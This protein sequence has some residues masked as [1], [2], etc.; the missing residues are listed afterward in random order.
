MSQLTKNFKERFLLTALIFNNVYIFIITNLFYTSTFGADYERYVNYLEYFIT[1]RESTD[2]DQGSLYFYL[3]S[4]GIKLNSK[5]I[6]P[7]NLDATISYSIQLVNF[8]LVLITLF[9]F[10][11][12]LRL[13]SFDKIPILAVLNIIVFSPQ[14]LALRLTMKPEIIILSLLPYLLIGV[15]MYMRNKKSRYLVFSSICFALIIS[16]KGTFLA[17]MPIFLLVYIGK[18]FN[19]LTVKDFALSLFVVCITALPIFIENYNINDNSLISRSVPDKYN[20]AADFDILYRNVDG[21]SLRFGPLSI[22]NNTIVGIALSDIYDDYFNMYWNKDVSMF[23]K[24]RKEIFLESQSNTWIKF[25]LENRHIYYKGNLSKILIESRLWLS[26]L[27]G[28]IFYCL[29]FYCLFKDQKYKK[30]YVGPLIGM[31]ILYI[32]ALGF[33]ENNFDPFTADTFKVFYYSPFVILTTVFVLLYFYKYKWFKNVVIFII[34][35]TVYIC[36]F[37]KQDSAQYFSDLNQSNVANPLCELNKFVI[38][39]IAKNSDCLDPE[40]EFCNLLV[41]PGID[42]SNIS[43]FIIENKSCN[44]TEPSTPLNQ[45]LARLP[46]LNILY[47]LYVL[48]FTLRLRLN[49]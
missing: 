41:N 26:R 30:M 49:H 28:V 20:N 27:L 4:I 10:Y 1:G 14:L 11:K 31:F 35:S 15:E 13:L 33:P 9:G 6:N 32:N 12:L 44:L 25:D 37:P 48:I 3:V 40:L 7:I 29:L 19:K 34:I 24:H 17:I 2:L 36:G 47:F 42:S 38:N 39:D 46:V 21:E 8:I 23:K 22:D 18:F 5:F 16:S 45:G 43:S